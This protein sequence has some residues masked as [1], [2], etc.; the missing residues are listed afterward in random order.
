VFSDQKTHL[1]LENPL[2]I[3]GVII[4]SLH[5][6]IDRA[7]LVRNHDVLLLNIIFAGNCIIMLSCIC[8][9]HE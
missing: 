6:E 1:K 9:S 3:I 4:I 8:S 5:F 2:N 7:L